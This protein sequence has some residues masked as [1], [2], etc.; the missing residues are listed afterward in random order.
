M[1]HII[2]IDLGTTNSLV[3]FWDGEKAVLIP[4]AHG[5]YLTP[6]V[7]GLDDNGDLLVGRVAKERLIT[8]PLKTAALF[9]R[10]MG[11]KKA[12][13]LGGVQT[14]QPEELSSF[15][16]RV[17]K[18]DAEAFLGAPVT[19]AVISVPAY[20]NDKQRKAT[21]IAGQ[22]AGLKVERLVN[23][24]TAAA[25]SY[26]LHVNDPESRFLV[27][28]LG[29]GTFDVSVLTLFDGIMEV[30]AT[31][32]HNTL[33]G[34]DFV[35]TLVKAFLNAHTLTSLDLS[36]M[37]RLRQHIEGMKRELTLQHEAT[38]APEF[39]GVA[40]PWHLTRDDFESLCAPLID[41]LRQPIE[42]ALNDAAITPRDLNCVILVGG[43]SR[44]PVVRSLAARLFGQYPIATLNP[45]EI[46]ALG[47]A[48]QAGL[49][50]RSQGLAEVVLTDVCPFTLGLE[51]ARRLPNGHLESGYYT[52]IIDRNTVV[53]VSRE[54]VFSTCHEGQTNM[55]LQI[56]QGES[57][58][59]RNNVKLGELEIEFPPTPEDEPIVRVR[60]TYDINGILEVQAT[61]LHEGNSKSTII[62]N[63][64]CDLSD[65]EIQARLQQLAE[66][67]IHPRER[68]E[69]RLL[70]A[71]GERLYE[72]LMGEAR[73][74]IAHEL[75]AFE[76]ALETQDSLHIRR[77]TKE[78]QSVFDEMEPHSL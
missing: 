19:E 72:Q 5:D 41:A 47:A 6:S 34:E 74:R 24:P 33:G 37:S 46:V 71:R 50:A 36:E 63:D 60:Y 52:P 25:L 76:D 11:T 62:R 54:K 42:R 53:P 70:L 77:V 2:G 35:D 65:A 45:D 51:T 13:S 10:Y 26:G 56:Y 1:S 67:K 28:D 78:I 69:S 57:R 12:Y 32:G 20:F 27:F 23:E 68:M 14:Y 31:A 15:L 21:Q 49:K 9:K 55:L 8:H 3:S 73:E 61:D 48:V 75:Q 29:G 58:L 39:G 30:N 16:L 38:I 7:I 44:M 64:S 43:A 17:L 4:N 59:T 66:I 22:L 40:Y 18:A